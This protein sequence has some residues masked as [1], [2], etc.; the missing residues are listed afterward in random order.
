MNKRVYNKTFGKIVRTLGFLLVLASSLY[1][2]TT[3]IL[4]NGSLPFISNLTPFAQTI[5][6]YLSVIPLLA[7]YTGLGL[8]VGLILILW[9]IRKGLILRILLTLVLVF[10]FLESAMSG[11]SALVPV[12]LLSPSWLS[13]V[14][15]LV[16]QFVDQ[17]TALSPYVVPGVGVAAPFLLWILFAYKK[18]GRFSLLM[19]RLGSIT[20]F[21]AILMLA[22]ANLF[23]TSLQ[24]VDIFST[25]NMMLYIITYLAFIIGGLFGTIGFTR[26]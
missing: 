5:D 9:A 3:L 19:L 16:G 12:T 23:V 22:V 1:I 11:T 26:K 21:L 17:L 10:G 20:L 2:A 4:E 25:I 7:E 13:G 24:T 8:V 18:P 15:T 6:G 14:V